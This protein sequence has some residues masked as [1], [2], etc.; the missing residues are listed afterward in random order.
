[1]K[2]E[3]ARPIYSVISN[4][5][6]TEGR[7]TTLY[8]GHFESESQAIEYG[9]GK[10]VMGSDAPVQRFPTYRIDGVHYGPIR[11]TYAS[12]EYIKKDRAIE[13]RRQ[14]LEKAEA[15]GLTK[16]EIDIIKGVL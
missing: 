11:V 12:D 1:M 3:E 2:I 10:Y 9:K 4:T 16:E 13:L 5:D 6:L 15:L 8:L 7:G 14:A